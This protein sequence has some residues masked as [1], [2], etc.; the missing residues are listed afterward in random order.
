MYY[1]NIRCFSIVNNIFPDKACQFILK[2]VDLSTQ[3][4]INA[5]S[6][7]WI[8]QLIINQPDNSFISKNQTNKHLV[9]T[10]MKDSLKLAYLQQPTVPLMNYC[11]LLLTLTVKIELVGK[12]CVYYNHKR[13]LPRSK[14]GRQQLR[15]TR[16]SFFLVRQW[17][18]LRSSCTNSY[19]RSL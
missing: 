18:T 6:K 13:S 12:W 3:L 15:F 17:P 11:R 19:Y 8:N 2:C 14:D 5:S 7:V 1:Q 10:N 9:I 4:R 16:P